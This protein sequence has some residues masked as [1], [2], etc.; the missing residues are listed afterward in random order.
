MKRFAMSLILTATLIAISSTSGSPSA[1]NQSTPLVVVNDRPEGRCVGR[2][3]P[4]LAILKKGSKVLESIPDLPEPIPACRMACLL[5][6]ACWGFA[7]KTG[8]N[9]TNM[10]ELY[11]KG[12]IEESPGGQPTYQWQCDENSPTCTSVNKS[13]CIGYWI[14][15]TKLSLTIEIL[16]KWNVTHNLTPD[17]GLAQM[18]QCP[19]MMQTGVGPFECRGLCQE[20]R[21]CTTA[22]HFDSSGPSAVVF[23]N[24]CILQD[25]N[26]PY[27]E[28]KDEQSVDLPPRPLPD[29]SRKL[30]ETL[31]AM[32]VSWFKTY[33]PFYVSW[34][35]CKNWWTQVN[36]HGYEQNEELRWCTPQQQMKDGPSIKNRNKAVHLEPDS[37]ASWIYKCVWRGIWR[38][39]ESASSKVFPQLNPYLNSVVPRESLVNE[40]KVIIVAQFYSQDPLNCPEEC[41]GNPCC[42][43]PIYIVNRWM[44]ILF[45]ATDG[46]SVCTKQ[47]LGEYEWGD[48]VS[49]DSLQLPN[50][51]V[52]V[53]DYS[54]CL[55]PLTNMRPNQSKNSSLE[56]QSRSTPLDLYT[57]CQCSN[58]N[59]EAI[60][61]LQT[62][63]EL[64]CGRSH[65]KR[66]SPIPFM[67][68]VHPPS[69]FLLDR[70]RDIV[71]RMDEAMPL[72]SETSI[73]LKKYYQKGEYMGQMWL[74]VITPFYTGMVLWGGPVNQMH[75]CSV[76]NCRVHVDYDFGLSEDGVGIQS[77]PG[78]NRISL[79]HEEH[80]IEIVNPDQWYQPTCTKQ[81]EYDRFNLTTT[82]PFIV[83]HDIAPG[84]SYAYAP[85][86]RCFTRTTCEH[87]LR[88]I[89][90]YYL[91]IGDFGTPFNYII[92]GDGTIYQG[93]GA[94]FVGAHTRG[95]NDVSFGIAFIGWYPF[96]VPS[97][98]AIQAFWRLIKWL[99]TIGRL[100]K[101]F[102]LYGHRDLRSGESPGLAL[103]RLLH[104]WPGTAKRDEYDKANELCRNP[105]G[106]PETTLEYLITGLVAS[107]LVTF[108]IVLLNLHHKKMQK[109]V[110]HT[111]DCQRLSEVCRQLET[112]HVLYITGK[113]LRD[114]KLT[115]LSCNSS[116]YD[117]HKQHV[118][119]NSQSYGSFGTVRSTNLSDCNEPFV[120]EHAGRKENPDINFQWSHDKLFGRPLYV[121][122]PRQWP[123]EYCIP[124]KA[125]LIFVISRDLQKPELSGQ[126]EQLT[127]FCR[128]W[129]EILIK[130]NFL[131]QLFSA[132]LHALVEQLGLSRSLPS[133]HLTL[134]IRLPSYILMAYSQT[135]MEK[136]SEFFTTVLSDTSAVTTLH[137]APTQCFIG[138][139]N[140]CKK[141]E[142]CRPLAPFRLNPAQ[143]P[144]TLDFVQIEEWASF[145]QKRSVYTKLLEPYEGGV[146]EFHDYRAVRHSERL[147]ETRRKP[148]AT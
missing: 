136:D 102:H 43:R 2:F 146:S 96:S 148:C 128:T 119:S 113:N 85:R 57:P 147:T 89:S 97:F 24:G 42:L 80:S 10:C 100:A 39:N 109:I 76:L 5:H 20:N 74:P 31:R 141:C 62:E 106:I 56:D 103:S 112:L 46:P 135:T 131:P 83:L 37:L 78:T 111:E 58:E 69:A 126:M 51:T 52:L 18:D 144:N 123:E 117:T 139:R 40:T 38:L 36:F 108:V 68:N 132:S 26:Q 59:E 118:L 30:R 122:D 27:P 1:N 61:F 49:L 48:L 114:S 4:I 28:Y 92:S 22:I 133:V 35:C 71:F 95:F 65:P 86:G 142:L 110:M 3:K 8:E 107:L 64:Q 130:Q 116:V 77:S 105:S 140:L 98:K 23:P 120:Y 53:W 25:V 75:N 67:K 14:R 87:I 50:H 9:Q 70:T 84:Y 12:A 137:S 104:T 15:E 124:V 93:R 129:K 91:S 44:C 81:N 29:L 6:Y 138:S 63:D 145:N 54:C 41:I 99:Q 125:S 55:L 143:K 13:R 79:A 82:I 94:E 121:I 115:E 127:T 66:F 90:L 17:A 32:P 88:S 60:V 11:P 34:V 16:Q 134:L 47:Y 21:H 33:P 45:G 73:H 101:K 19:P 72:Q 7:P